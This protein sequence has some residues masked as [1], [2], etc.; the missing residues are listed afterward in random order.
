MPKSHK[1]GATLASEFYKPE[2]LKVLPTIHRGQCCDCKI[3]T[4]SV[5][6]WLCRVEGGITIENYLNGRWT[7]P[8]G[9][10]Q[11][12]ITLHRGARSWFARFSGPEEQR[13]RQLFGTTDICT[14]FLAAADP[15]EVH[16]AIAKLNPDYLVVINDL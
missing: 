6:V 4:G 3:D 12:L 8:A 7:I 11:K 15:D 10:D 16:A 5:R 2:D 9:T 1:F 13:I 14:A